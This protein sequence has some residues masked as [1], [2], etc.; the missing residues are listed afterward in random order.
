MI[1]IE[2]TDP[3]LVPK[4]VM[5]KTA[6]YLMGTVGLPMTT[7]MALLGSSS[8]PTQ[9]FWKDP[10]PTRAEV[11]KAPVH[12]ETPFGNLPVAT[13]G[14]FYNPQTNQWQ[15][16]KT[17][18]DND[19]VLVNNA[20]AGNPFAPVDSS[21]V[22]E[23]MSSYTVTDTGSKTTPAVLTRDPEEL[24]AVGL[25]WD[26]RI[27]SRTKSKTS[28]GKWRYQRGVHDHVIT[29]V[30]AEL[31]LNTG[32]PQALE[33]PAYKLPPT[34]VPAAVAPPPPY[35]PPAPVAPLIDLMAPKADF[36][37]FMSKVTSLNQTGKID[38]ER[39]VL[40]IQQFGIPNIPSVATRPDLIPAIMKAIDDVVG[41]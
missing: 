21:H 33:A 29:R 27:H 41:A 7:D 32:T 8:A 38:R 25:P 9:G 19:N 1:K 14:Q 2:I 10:E 30:E 3:H 23:N 40:I 24:D 20:G 17:R 15:D 37:T 35:V 22:T 34:P 31:K 28:D 11:T 36:P 5:Y 39:V 12:F 16:P 13:A 18:G 6:K 26:A 4:D